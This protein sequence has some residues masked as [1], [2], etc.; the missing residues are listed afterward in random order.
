MKKDL[1]LY[2]ELID[3]TEGELK[4]TEYEDINKRIGDLLQNYLSLLS[5]YKDY[6]SGFA[7]DL[8]SLNIKVY[9]F[10]LAVLH[11]ISFE[12]GGSRLDDSFIYFL[13]ISSYIQNTLLEHGLLIRGVITL[14]TGLSNEPLES[15]M[16][17]RKKLNSYPRIM[18]DPPLMRILSANFAPPSSMMTFINNSI[19]E[20][21]AINFF[22]NP[23][24][25]S[26]L[27]PKQ[28]EMPEKFRRLRINQL[29]EQIQA[30][31]I[32]ENRYNLFEPARWNWGFITWLNS[33]EFEGGDPANNF[34]FR[35][36]NLET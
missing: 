34:H 27:N 18:I 10:N 22:L 35:F 20:D 3:V 15:Q 11:V 32:S 7:C 25:I 19:L 33:K 30:K 23:F 29:A 12:E 26:S 1:H 13:I 4:P 28:V 14:D 9:K 17:V 8:D 21:W 31:V 2:F 36:I 24:S 16:E 5:N 6:K